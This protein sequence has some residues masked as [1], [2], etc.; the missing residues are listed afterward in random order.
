M[1]HLHSRQLSDVS[2]R[3]AGT[4][5]FRGASLSH[6]ARRYHHDRRLQVE[7]LQK[8]W[9]MHVHPIFHI[10]WREF[11]SN[12]RVYSLSG[13]SVVLTAIKALEMAPMCIL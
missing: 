5:L 3:N 4:A 1:A 2:S 7:T 11:S 10:P 8:C 6:V 13:S 9:S 12:L